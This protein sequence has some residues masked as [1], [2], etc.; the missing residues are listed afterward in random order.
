MEEAIFAAHDALSH[1]DA[2]PS[3]DACGDLRKV[4]PGCEKMW[5]LAVCRAFALPLYFLHTCTS[6]E[7]VW[8]LSKGL[9]ATTT[10]CPLDPVLC[11]KPE[12][13]AAAIDPKVKDPVGKAGADEFVDTPSVTPAWSISLY[14]GASVSEPGYRAPAQQGLSRDTIRNSQ[15]LLSI[16]P[17]PARCEVFLGPV[18]SWKD[19]ATAERAARAARDIC[20]PLRAVVRG[21]PLTR[22]SLSVSLFHTQVARTADGRATLPA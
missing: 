7:R 11:H 22:Q 2:L 3:V 9:A 12:D 14:S 16:W 6:S 8:F 20:R 15:A 1:R 4:L 21:C 18:N 5:S 13:S 19:F 10:C 17:I